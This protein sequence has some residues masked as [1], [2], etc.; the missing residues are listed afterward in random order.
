MSDPALRGSE[1]TWVDELP[2][3]S[4]VWHHGNTV[5]LAAPNHNTETRR[6]FTVVFLADGYARAKP[7]PNFALD[8]A[9]VAVGEQMAGDGLPLVWPRAPGVSLPPPAPV[10]VG[11]GTGPQQPSSQYQQARL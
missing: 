5:H 6:V 3:G 2:V 9:G 8:R 7:W 4:I 10:V 1:P 11:A